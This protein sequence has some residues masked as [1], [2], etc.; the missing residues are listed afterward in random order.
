MVEQH[1]RR[2]GTP[3][4]NGFNNELIWRANRWT[5]ALPQL[6]AGFFTASR[7]ERV[8]AAARI[9]REAFAA[10]FGLGAADT[11]PLWYLC[12]NGGYRP[13]AEEMRCRATFSR[14]DF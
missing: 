9:A 1:L 6:V 3:A 14:V 11:P 8:V 13:S 2:K 5:A 4:N 12:T 10:R 7:D